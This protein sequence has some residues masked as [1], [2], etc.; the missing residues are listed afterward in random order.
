M[1]YWVLAQRCIGV[2]NPTVQSF[3]KAVMSETHARMQADKDYTRATE[4]TEIQK[5]E[6]LVDLVK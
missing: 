1:R 4:D 3:T 5:P 6:K 2:A